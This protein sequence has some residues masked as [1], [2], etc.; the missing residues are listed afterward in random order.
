MPPNPSFGRLCMDAIYIARQTAHANKLSFTLADGAK[1]I[2]QLDE[3]RIPAS[4]PTIQAESQGRPK[5]SNPSPFGDRKAIPPTPEQVTAYSASIGY[6]MDGQKWCD[7]YAAKGWSVG[8]TK[9]K[10]WQAAV[11]NWKTNGWG[12]GTVA[13]AAAKKDD[14]ETNYSKF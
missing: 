12:L 2:D 13:M 5:S 3:G 8:R 1:I 10:D 11:R 6:P 4:T 14:K 9:M 7:Q